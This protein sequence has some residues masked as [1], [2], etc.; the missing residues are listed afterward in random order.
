MSMNIYVVLSGQLDLDDGLYDIVKLD[1]TG[2]EWYFGDGFT[3]VNGI[4]D[5]ADYHAVKSLYKLPD[6]FK[7]EPV[8]VQSLPVGAA[9][10]VLSRDGKPA[11]VIQRLE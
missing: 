11:K 6:T 2:V 3:I 1:N 5:V 7:Y 8:S 10:I 9:S 4:Q